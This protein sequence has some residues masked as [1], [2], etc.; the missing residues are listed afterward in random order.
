VCF[1]LY[2]ALQTVNLQAAEI[3]GVLFDDSY[4]RGNITLTLRGTGLLKYLFLVEVYVAA[5]YLEEKVS[6]R[7]ALED[8]PKRLEIQYFHEIKAE[9]FVASTGKLIEANQSPETVAALQ[10]KIERLN[11]LYDDVRPGDRYALT[12]LPGTGTELSL[13]GQAKG[14]IR[15]ADFSAALFSMWLGP[16]PIDSGL[17]RQ[18]L[19]TP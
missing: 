10:P 7:R 1:A 6:S 15:G 9:D 13:N 19:N 14:T 16:K 3:E 18:L 8:V 4:S 17:K 12:Y 11:G 2:V 5:L